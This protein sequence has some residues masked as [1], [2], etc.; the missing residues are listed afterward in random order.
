MPPGTPLPTGTLTFLF[1]DIEGSTRLLVSLGERFTDVLEEHQRLLREAFNAGREVGTE[2]DS[3]FVVFGSARDAVVAAAAAQRALAAHPWK[4]AAGVRVRIGLHTGEGRLGGDNYVGLDVHRGARIAAAAH[5]GQVLLSETTGALVAG[6][7]PEGVTIRDLGEHQLKDLARREHLFQLAISGL[8]AE[9]DPPSALATRPNNLPRQLNSFVGRDEELGRIQQLLASSA[10]VT[11]TG[12][13]GVGKTRLALQVAG[14]AIDRYPDGTFLVSLGGLDDSAQVLAEVA[15]TVGLRDAGLA[16]YE[17]RLG[18]YL[19][20]RRVLLVLDNMEHLLDAGPSI[21]DLLREAPELKILVTSRARLRLGGEQEFPVAPLPVSQ[22][23]AEATGSIST[24]ASTLFVERATA[25]DPTFS[26]TDED[27]A[28]IAAICARLDGLPLAIE[29]AASRV[30]LATP[31]QILELLASSLDLLGE[32]GR[33]MPVR[34]RTLQSTIEWSYGLLDPTDAAVLDRLS[35][36]AG[37][38]D[39]D[40]AEAVTNPDAELTEAF[41]SPLSHLVE[42]SLVS[43]VPGRALERRFRLLQTIRDVASRRL[44]AASGLRDRIV[45]RHRAHFVALAARLGPQLTGSQMQD[46]FDQLAAEHDNIREILRETLAREDGA[47]ALEL[48]SS[49]WRFW[50][51]SGH[52]SE[53]RDWVRRALA[54][55]SASTPSPVRARGLLTA[56]LLAYWQGDN[57]AFRQAVSESSEMARALDDLPLLVETLAN[58]GWGLVVLDPAGA[59]QLFDEALVLA[60]RVGDRDSAL[61]CRLGQGRLAAFQGDVAAT[62]RIM[63]AALVD[64]EAIGDRNLVGVCYGLL[65]NAARSRG[66]LQTA[67]DYYR[68]FM[69]IPNPSGNSPALPFGLAQI[70]NVL[71]EIEPLLAVRISGAVEALSLQLGMVVSWDELGFPYPPDEVRRSLPEH[72]VAA[73]HAEGLR[74]NVQEA[75]EMVDEALERLTA[76]LKAPPPSP[77]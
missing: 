46:A 18:A 76:A 14:E 6:D 66:D 2:G 58:L 17:E 5:G 15:R 52:M 75:L 62:E 53:G 63:S 56:G 61:L 3:F 74:L 35:V 44:A 1:S 16:T 30:N 34:Q 22:G 68:K 48:A 24:P 25:V 45:G 37:G 32:G 31:R 7:L 42:Q 60:A 72:I 38:F 9:F 69:R 65:G 29:L 10:L 28:A 54:T 27:S 77:G 13:G 12:P 21:G 41:L 64:L 47:A 19:R 33:D 67:V 57:A 49:V 51:W 50:A 11:L 59:A 71:R 70:A 36:F 40:A 39:L 23:T 73:A 8:P 20:S 26:V 4:H 43:V 55:P